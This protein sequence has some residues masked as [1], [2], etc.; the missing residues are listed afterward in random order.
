[1]HGTDSNEFTNTV[2]RRER[3]RKTKVVKNVKKKTEIV[4]NV[5]SL[6]AQFV[7]CEVLYSLW[8]NL[9]V[10]TYSL[11]GPM[12]PSR[13]ICFKYTL[14]CCKIKNKYVFQFQ[15]SALLRKNIL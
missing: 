2:Q 7:P 1:V 9:R 3:R 8:S 10:Y 13:N 4:K 14:F 6:F 12:L 5:I 15:M 11:T